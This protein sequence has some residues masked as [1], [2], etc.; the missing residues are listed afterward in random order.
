MIE[1]VM[2]FTC[3]LKR[4]FHILSPVGFTFGFYIGVRYSSE[5]TLKCISYGI[6][7]SV[8]LPLYIITSPIWGTILVCKYVL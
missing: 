4:M 8:F 7:G 3:C 5:N 6:I 1:K 2:L